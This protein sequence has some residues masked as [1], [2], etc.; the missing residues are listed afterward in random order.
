MSLPR[1][2]ERHS[3]PLGIRS[4]TQGRAY[5]GLSYSPAWHKIASF[6]VGADDGSTAAIYPNLLDTKTPLSRSFNW[7][8]PNPLIRFED[9]TVWG[10]EGS[11][12]YKNKAA[13]L[14]LE[15][16]YERFETRE[17]KL[18]KD[19]G[20]SEHMYLLAKELA[21][22]V[23]SGKTE[24]LGEALADTAAQD[25]VT[26]A[27]T[28]GREARDIDGK[29]CNKK[30]AVDDERPF[31]IGRNVG[32]AGSGKG[33]E[34]ARW[35][36]IDYVDEV[37]YSK[38][39]FTRSLKK[40]K[41]AKGGG[42]SGNFADVMGASDLRSDYWGKCKV[43]RTRSGGGKMSSRFGVDCGTDGD[44]EEELYIYKVQKKTNGGWPGT[45]VGKIDTARGMAG[46]LVGNLSG[47]EKSAV[48]GILTRTVSGGEVIE[49]RA[50]TTTS[51][52]LNA[53]YDL[54]HKKLS[55]FGC[56]G[57][58]ANFVS[59]TDGHVAPKLAYKLKAGLSCEIAPRITAFVS[60]FYHRVL[61]DGEYYDVPVQHL[62]DDQSPEGR[63]KNYALAKFRLAYTGAEVGMRFAF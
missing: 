23:V 30:V 10:F 24:K 19:T 8:A 38:T 26:F 11:V 47:E 15:I 32:N 50:V 37:G 25:I 61:G 51:V 55:P 52:M 2:E 63:S 43:M 41:K 44:S 16:G 60:G 7:Q 4:Q 42:L 34:P 1:T 56:L 59:I 54:Q 18:D 39:P 3:P 31:H 28:V 49:L 14:E 20:G 27:Q 9:N 58:G 48:A 53:C 29:V 5:I 40:G 6:A 46:D 13:R 17:T 35:S 57:F 12:G 21:H 22:S 36:C 33:P 45:E 62:L